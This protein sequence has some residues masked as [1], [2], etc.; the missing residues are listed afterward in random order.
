M[1]R[2]R[3]AAAAATVA[4]AGAVVIADTPSIVGI[5]VAVGAAA[6]WCRWLEHHPEP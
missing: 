2:T 1:T 4:I 3:A 6:V 5:T